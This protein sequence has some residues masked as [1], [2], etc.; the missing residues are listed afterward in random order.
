MKHVRNAYLM[1]G[2]FCASLLASPLARANAVSEWNER[3]VKAVYAA[4]LTCSHATCESSM[5]R[6]S[7]H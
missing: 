1:S 4:R 6:S 3:A 2:V 5:S 7:R